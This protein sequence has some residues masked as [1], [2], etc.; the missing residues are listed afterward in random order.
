MRVTAVP[1]RVQ[2]RWWSVVALLGLLAAYS[3]VASASQLAGWSGSHGHVSLSGY[4]APHAH[5]WDTPSH[6]EGGA[7][8]AGVA[9]TLSDG[10]VDAGPTAIALPDFGASIQ[11]PA[12]PRQALAEAFRRPVSA[13]VLTPAP[14]PRA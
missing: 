5:P 2:M 12:A 10:G 4:V 3:P 6:P 13:V 7:G 8:S 9:F 14:H 1:T 11:Q